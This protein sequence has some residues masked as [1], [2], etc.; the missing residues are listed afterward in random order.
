MNDQHSVCP[1]EKAVSLEK[2]W[3]K[4]LHHPKKILKPYVREGMT[5]LDVGCGPGF[6]TIPLA[7]MVGQNGKVI[8]TDIQ[9]GMLDK[10]SSKINGTELENRVDLQLTPQDSLGV[11]TPVDFVL[12][13][14]V[15]HELPDIEKF[16]RE[17][18]T[19]LKPDG[20]ILVTDPTFHVSKEEFARTLELIKRAGFT[21]ISQPRIWFSR[22]ALLES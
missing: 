10:V 14:Y 8:A 7:E 13:F 9:Q 16:L 2:G 12:A 21:V 19:I 11:T 20:K 15:L 18:K 22:T 17:I 3:R 6:F 5:V 1:M 4:W